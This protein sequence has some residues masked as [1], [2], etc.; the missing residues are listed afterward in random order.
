MKE[1]LEKIRHILGEEH[2]ST[3][4]AMNN[5]ASTLKVLGQL[6]DAANMSSEVLEKRRCI[7]GK[8]HPD[9]ILAMN[10]L[11]FTLGEQGQLDKAITLSKVALQKMK[12][13]HGEGHPHTKIAIGN[14][15]RLVASRAA[16][17][18]LAAD[19][20]RNKKNGKESS[21]YVRC[22]KGKFLTKVLQT[23]H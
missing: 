1:V 18:A 17:E 20:S 4:L 14:W 15:T 23:R 11:A 19:K 7:L 2:P 10:D 5:L 3:T 21:L 12:R 16:Y 22:I 13:L 8:D 6:D 9:A